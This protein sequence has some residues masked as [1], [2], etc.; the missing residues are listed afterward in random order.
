VAPLIRSLYGHPLA[1]ASWQN[2]LSNI[3][4]THLGGYELEEQPSCFHFPALNLALS[5]YVDDLTLSGP[6]KNHSQFWS[7]L[8]KHV[9]LEDPAELSKVLGRNHVPQDQGGL[10]LHSADFAKQ[11]VELYEQ[12][13]GKKAKHFRT[14]HCDSG[15][16]VESDDGCVGQLSASSARLVMK[17][18]WLGRISRPDILVAINT[19]ARHITK[20]SANDDK[21]AARLVG[22]IAATIDHAHVM[23]INDPPAELWLSLYVDSDFGSSPDMKSTGG[24]IIALQVPNSFAVILWGSKTRRAVSRSTTEA[25]FVALSTALF[26][27]AI[28]LLSVCQKLIASTLVLKVYEDNQAVLAIIAKGYSPKLKHLA[29]FHRINVA[30]TCEAFSV[31][32]ILIEYVS[33]SHQKADVMNKALP[34]SVWPHVLD[35]LS[36][37]SVPIT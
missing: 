34:V 20:W 22:Y 16:L 29:K 2:H 19:L 15:T 24:F 3:L 23:R 12:L 27:D 31:E 37:K 13:S 21:R 11:C 9:Q 7:T 14:P 32:D 35:L 26:G 17:L 30:S 5:V 33:T 25:E 18:M 8:R 28:S 1:S 4:S 36:I 6:K 10:A